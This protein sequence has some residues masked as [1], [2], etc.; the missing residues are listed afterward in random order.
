MKHWKHVVAAI[1]MAILLCNGSVWADGHQGPSAIQVV[2]VDTQG[3]TEAYLKAISAMPTLLAKLSPGAEV[4][5]YEAAYSGQSTGRV[6]VVITFP[7]LTSLAESTDKLNADQQWQAMIRGLDATG[8][9]L[10]SNSI[11]M[12]R[13]PK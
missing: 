7:S 12:D 1:C 2:A 10:T 8:R 4:K 9:T 5:V 3:N 11:L 13:T 6:Y